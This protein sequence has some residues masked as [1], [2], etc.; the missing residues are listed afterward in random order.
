[1]AAE[2]KMVWSANHS[3]WGTAAVDWCSIEPGTIYIHTDDNMHCNP[4]YAPYINNLMRAMSIY[5][6][7][8]KCAA[9]LQK[10]Y[11]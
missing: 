4:K 10:K 11:V 8:K 5:I 1:M 3:I 2:E 6:T 7:Q 9:Y